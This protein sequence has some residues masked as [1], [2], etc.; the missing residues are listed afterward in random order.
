[1]WLRYSIYPS[2]GQEDLSFLSSLLKHKKSII[3]KIKNKF[4][5]LSFA[6]LHLINFLTV[7]PFSYL[8]FYSKYG[9]MFSQWLYNYY[10]N[11]VGLSMY[12]SLFKFSSI[13]SLLPNL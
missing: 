7:S 1:M 6:W 4:T 3:K 2:H 11:C 5:L 9:P 8:I 12:N 13:V 10:H